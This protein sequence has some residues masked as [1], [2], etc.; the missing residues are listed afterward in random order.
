MPTLALTRL[1]GAWGYAVGALLL[2]AVLSRMPRLALDPRRSR[3]VSHGVDL[4]LLALWCAAALGTVYLPVGFLLA[5]AARATT[6]ATPSALVV[7]AALGVLLATWGSLV[8]RRWPRIRRWRVPVRNLAHDLVGYRVVQLSDLHIGSFDDRAQGLAWA[9]RANRERAD[10]VVVTG[11]LVTT[12]THY[13][14]DA[15]D[16]LGALRAPDGVLVSF[17]NHD[18]WDTPAF[19]RAI[20]ARGARVLENAWTRI[21]RGDA[22]LV[23]AGL[24]DRFAGRDDLDAT[25]AARPHDAPTLLLSHYP[26]FFERAADAGVDLV[27]SGHTHAG[28]LALWPWPRLLNVATLTGQRAWGLYR[29]GASTLYVNAGLGVTGPPVRVGCP[30]EI[31]VFELVRA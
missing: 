3:W 12:G 31:A 24:G 23:V 17:G 26:S 22:A 8:E 7:A 16:V 11:D 14:D 18:G 13:Y 27:L 21:V 30:P 20:E 5:W 28:Q 25:L 6:G 1:L 29:R 19:A 15:A 2:G 10:L 4:P 9:A